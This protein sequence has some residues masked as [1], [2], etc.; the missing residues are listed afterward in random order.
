MIQLSD[1][2]STGRLLRF[3]FPSIIMM[4][5]TSVYGVVDGFFVSNFAGKEAFTA[6]NFVM[7]VIM[8]LGCGGFMFGTGGSALI[9]KTLGEGDREKADRQ[10][11]MLI[12]ASAISGT[13]VAAVGFIIIRHVLRLLGADGALI[14]NCMRYA[15][16][17]MPA[18]PV[19]FLQY[20]FQSIFATAEKPKLGLYVTVAAGITN[21]ILDALFVGVFRWG[22][23]GAAVATSLS[24]LIGGL[25]P[26][27]YFFSRKNTSMLYLSKPVF[28]F[29]ALLKVCANGSSEV[30]STVSMS[31]IGMLYNF[32]LLKYAGQDGIAAYGVLMYVNMIFLAVFIGF[33]N[34]TAPVVGYH[35][36]AQDLPEL[37]GIL[38]RSLKIIIA[39]SV[40]M[41]FLAQL[42]AKPLAL[43]FVSY[44]AGLMKMTLHA[45]SIYSF[46]FLFSGI[47]IYGSSFF[48]ALND[49]LTSAVVSFMRTLIFET[50][51]ILLLPRILG[52]DG[53]W[54]STVVAEIMAAL[55]TVMFLIIKEK[56]YHYWKLPDITGDTAGEKI[57]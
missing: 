29:R 41:L 53:I 50:A 39:F 56:K 28:D 47:A 13:I 5:F 31:L 15:Q 9:S 43:L 1:H 37:Q 40:S 12:A 18:I 51:S 48:T 3:S 30:M 20:E 38:K 34:G 57:T 32:Q 44:D 21:M 22:I 42:L 46:G 6:V 11:S 25:L 33:S 49:G 52:I 23:T 19:L 17:V 36:G 2:F 8:I 10:F 26:V 54:S 4:A 35:Y 7:P 14:E 55:L 45:F 16:C 27:C 24:Q